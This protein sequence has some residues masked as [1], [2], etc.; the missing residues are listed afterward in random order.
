MTR[1]VVGLGAILLVASNA[2]G[3]VV[4]VAAVKDS[5]IFAT[6]AGVDTGNASG[7]GPILQAGADGSSNRRRSLIAFD[8]ASAGLPSDATISNVTMTLYLA[9]AAG[10][11]SYP[12][13]TIRLFALQQNWGEGSSGSPTSPGV[14]GA[15]QGYPRVTGDS[16]WDYALYD[17]ANPTAGTWN[18]SG[19]SLHGGNFASLESA[20]STSTSFATLNAPFE[21][22]SPGM[23]AEVQHW[24]SGGGGAG[25]FGWLIKSD[26]ED[27]PTSFLAFWSRDGA[28]AKYT[29]QAPSM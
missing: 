8:L 10:G 17:S 14:A 21:W 15:G 13:R 25:N 27:M 12:S 11:G 16:S 28:A 9:Q 4:T 20:G 18:N 26:L 3:S 1:V 24:V 5:T 19:T 29:Y 23:V 22:S 2:R 7:K 6:S